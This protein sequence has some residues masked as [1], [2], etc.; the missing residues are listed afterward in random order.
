MFYS[1]LKTVCVAHLATASETQAAGRGF[2][3]HPYH[4]NTS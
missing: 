4:Y 2:K 1:L 3:T